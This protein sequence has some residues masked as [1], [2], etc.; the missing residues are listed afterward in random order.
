VG[1][2]AAPAGAPL[3]AILGAGLDHSTQ[4][5]VDRG[6]AR[7]ALRQ[8]SLASLPLN[9]GILLED[10]A[11]LVP[12]YVRAAEQVRSLLAELR[13][14]GA[15][16]IHA[17]WS[18]AVHYEAEL[19]KFFDE[20]IE[21]LRETPVSSTDAVKLGRDWTEWMQSTYRVLS[22]RYFGDPPMGAA[23]DK[24]EQIFRESEACLARLVVLLKPFSNIR[25][26]IGQIED[27]APAVSAA[28]SAM[29]AWL[30]GGG[31][32]PWLAEGI[33]KLLEVAL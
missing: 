25:R 14:I 6:A 11:F 24:I 27:D 9:I 3:L 23:R 32:L 13:A 17:T 22:K 1:F 19:R 20:E 33:A 5:I 10:E 12:G 31:E 18:V 8:V 2:G 26:T 4:D 7:V 29:A 30:H 21:R 16:N 15:R 28:R